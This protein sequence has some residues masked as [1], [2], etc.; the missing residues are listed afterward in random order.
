[1]IM[2]TNLARAF[3]ILEFPVLFQRRQQEDEGRSRLR[4]KP[5]GVRDI[6]KQ[7]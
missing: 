3:E 7:E 1:M 2:K 6:E 4:T 5:A